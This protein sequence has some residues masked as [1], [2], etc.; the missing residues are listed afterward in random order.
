[1]SLWRWLMGWLLSSNDMPLQMS[2]EWLRD[3]IYR[4]GKAKG[5]DE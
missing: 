1:M 5:S 3:G 2:N 4:R